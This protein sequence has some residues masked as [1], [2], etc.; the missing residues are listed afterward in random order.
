MIGKKTLVSIL[1]LLISFHIHAKKTTIIANA[2]I[3]EKNI[4][5]QTLMLKGNV[6]VIFEQNHLLCDEAFIDE[7]NKT[8]IATG[9]V[10]LQNQRT[11]FRGE[12]IEMN[13]DNEKGRFYNGVITSGQVLFQSELIEKIGEDEYTAKDAYYTACLTCPASWGFTS[14]QV[15]AKIGDYA[16]I[17]RPWLHLMELPT[18]P[19]PY[20]VVPLNT[21][22]RTGLLVPKSSSNADGGF[23]IEQPFYWAINQSSDATFSL[24]RYEKRGFQVLGNYRYMLS[25]NSSGEW[26][27]SFL[28]DR[29]F[30]YKERWFTQY[31][32]FW[33]LPQN[34]TQ[35][36]ELALTTDRSF[37]IDFPNQLRYSGYAALDNSLSLT[38]SMKSSLLT[39]DTSYYISLI[40]P[41]IHLKDNRD[42]HRMP[43][44]NFNLADQRIFKKQNL[45]F[46][47]DLQ[48]LNIAR[49]RGRSFEHTRSGTDQCVSIGNKDQDVCYAPVGQKDPFVY[50]TDY[51]GEPSANQ[52]GDLIR[53]GQR[54]DIMPSFHAPFWLGSGIDMD[55]SF[56][57]RMTQYS[58]GVKSDPSQNYDSFPSRFYTQL[59]LSTKT[60]MSRMFEWNQKTRV[61]HTLIPEIDIK[62]IPKV[63]QSNHH[64]FGT[65]EVLRYF[66]EQQP[67]DDTD[68]HWRQGGRGIQFDQNDR[69]IGR[70][71]VNFS[72]TNK[73]LSRSYLTEQSNQDNL[74]NRNTYNENL[75]FRISQAF[76]LNEAKNGDNAK[77][78]QDIRA[79]ARFNAGPV[80][81]SILASHFPYHHRT[82]WQTST[83]YNFMPGNTVSLS[84][85][86]NYLIENQPPVDESTKDELILFGTTIN[87]KYLY[88]HG[89]VEYDL[90]ARRELG[91]DNFKR[92]R[93]TTR[94][95]PPGSC[96]FIKGDIE[97]RLDTGIVNYSISMQFAFGQ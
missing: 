6:N 13:Y 37:V 91:E 61:K 64:F 46:N 16:A 40:E 19:L 43:E 73:I 21:K 56:A 3:V 12:K 47:L 72:L 48:Y 5:E 39:L 35:R 15:R 96:W 29:S 71:I 65:R 75:Y 89:L 97:N 67:I 1:I 81:Q 55:P 79:D 88:L 82:L 28:K 95:I 87:F 26:N 68:S 66:R 31:K 74:L 14:S 60:Y 85:T 25:S 52:Y 18:L 38:K 33:E 32:H 93:I 30:N 78:W 41:E 7:E 51:R 70:Q 53:A 84:Y 23:T 63:H 49:Y 58:L 2:D 50:G 8:I 76:D 45:F 80:T 90:T 57:M 17:H 77:P 9:N 59:G 62:Y 94:F 69:V 83:H 44:I 34:Y 86:K 22:R 20:L 92:W 27:G 36:T 10:V 42:L 4:S 24:I 54:L 11:T